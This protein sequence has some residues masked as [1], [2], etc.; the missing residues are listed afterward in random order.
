[1]IDDEPQHL[2]CP[3]TYS[4]FRDPVVVCQSG[5]TYERAAIMKHFRWS[6]RDPSSGRRLT[7]TTVV[8]NVLA[9]KCVEKWLDDNPDATPA[10]WKSRVVPS[11]R[12]DF[13]DAKK[14]VLN[15]MC[16]AVYYFVFWIHFVFI[17]MYLL[18]R[19][20]EENQFFKQNR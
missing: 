1:M 8:T 19:G 6:L 14:S 11:A 2:C 7:D 9:R 12:F 3:I 10:G 15:V 17:G 5:Q 16:Y 4:M 18:S 13:E 20:G